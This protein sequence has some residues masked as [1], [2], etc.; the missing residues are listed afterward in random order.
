M[1]TYY[2]DSAS[3]LCMPYPIDRCGY[4]ANNFSSPDICASTCTD[5]PCLVAGA[6]DLPCCSDGVPIRSSDLVA[7]EDLIVYPMFG[8]PEGCELVDCWQHLSSRIS[9]PIDPSDGASTCQFADECETPEDCVMLIN[10]SDC[11]GCAVQAVPKALPTIA[12]DPCWIPV[13]AAVPEE[14]APTDCTDVICGECTERTLACEMG[15]PE[16]Y[17]HCQ[18]VAAN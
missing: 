1:V 18:A 17:M 9:E 11:C 2:F 15:Y 12:L 6:S 4:G 7:A 14:C 10:S 5:D 3:G 13:G 8:Y 16:P